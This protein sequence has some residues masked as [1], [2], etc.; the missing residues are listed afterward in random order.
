MGLGCLSPNDPNTIYISTGFDPRA[1][2][3]GVFDT[4]QPASSVHEIWRGVTT[5]HG[6]SFTW[7]PV[8]QKSS[9]DNFRPIVPA[10]DSTHTLL[11][12]FRG[13][14]TSAQIV[15]A[16]VVGLRTTRT[17]DLLTA[18]VPQRTGFA[19]TRQPLDRFAQWLLRAIAPLSFCHSRLARYAK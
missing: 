7:T 16:I 18:S 6:A 19:T 2:K 13:T 10:W 1:V 5:N 8:T 17:L 4:N 11:C 15:D 9:R 14:Y 3:P 12:W